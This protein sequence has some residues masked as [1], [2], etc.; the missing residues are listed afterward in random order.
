MSSIRARESGYTMTKRV[1][2]IGA[3][4]G[5]G[6]ALA[7]RLVSSGYQVIATCRNKRQQNYLRKQGLCQRAI[8]LD[9]GRNRSIT[10]AFQGLKDQGVKALAASINCAAITQSSLLEDMQQADFERIMQV[11]VA[12]TFHAARLSIPLLR[13]GQGRLIFVGS[14]GGDMAL[15]ALGAYSASKF[16]LEALAD[17]F[18]RELAGCNI[19]VSLIKPGAI[20]SNMSQKHLEALDAIILGNPQK[21]DEGSLQQYRAHRERIAYGYRTGVEPDQVATVV[22]KAL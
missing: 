11:N 22:I 19:P 3:T 14:S 18:R 6:E 4:G 8:L 15:P 9:L 1:L 16:A 10:Q 20:R 2:L 21:L 7:M 12:G 17:T 5:V 13:E